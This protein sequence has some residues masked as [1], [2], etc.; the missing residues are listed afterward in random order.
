MGSESPPALSFF[1]EQRTSLQ[2]IRKVREGLAEPNLS[3]SRGR[4]PVFG[5]L[6][7][8]EVT[9]AYLY[10]LVEPPGRARLETAE[11]PERSPRPTGGDRPKR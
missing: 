11:A 10:L 5:Y 1:T 3:A 2:V 9:A 6:S 4:M 7:P 8:Q